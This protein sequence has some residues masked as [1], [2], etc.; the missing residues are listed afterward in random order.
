MFDI[1]EKPT[2]AVLPFANLSRDP[3]QFFFCR[4]FIRRQH[5]SAWVFARGG[6]DVPNVVF[7]FQGANRTLEGT[8]R[9][10]W[11]ELAVNGQ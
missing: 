4:R 3:D 1:S 11:L 7:Y 5:L 2:I 6:R 8:V 10:N 9:G